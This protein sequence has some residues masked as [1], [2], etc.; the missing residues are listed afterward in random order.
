MSKPIMSSLSFGIKKIHD[1][2]DQWAIQ[3]VSTLIILSSAFLL[4][5][6]REG[7]VKDVGLTDT[8]IRDVGG[9]ITTGI[10]ILN[11]VNPYLPDGTLWGGARWGT[12]GTVPLAIISELIPRPLQVVFFQILGLLGFYLFVKTIFR[13]SPKLQTYSIFL[14]VIWSSSYREMLTTNQIIG[15]VLGLIALGIR[16]IF[17]NEGGAS[18]QLK[19]FLGTLCFV[20]ALD[21]KP[22]ISG[23]LIVGLYIYF[24]RGKDFLWLAGIYLITH[25]VVDVYLKRIVELDWVKIVTGLSDRANR[26]ELGDSVTFWPVLRRLVNLG[27]SFG[28]VSRAILLL[29]VIFTFL[30]AYRKN[31][32]AFFFLSFF[33]P[34]FSIYFHYY[35]AVPLFCLVFW[36]L[37]SR[38]KSIFSFLVLDML[39]ISKEAS[40]L[41]N[42][43]LVILISVLVVLFSSNSNSMR[44]RNLIYAIVGFIVWQLVYIANS[45]SNSNQ[46]ELQSLVVTEVLILSFLFFIQPLNSAQKLE[47]FTKKG[48]SS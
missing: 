33:T 15:I 32:H 7:G 37:L 27:N 43:L 8:S 47:I 20:I 31:W 16:S 12:F 30:V 3:A 14:L 28:L 2:L 9:Y 11:R 4:Y 42:I 17:L 25:A 29:L 5:Q 21:L 35:D 23:L 24:R 36:A 22:H 44:F 45:R 40:S 1:L 48:N 19:H 39:V 26:N 13:N 41:K 46:Y 6:Y 34:A 18:T 38:Q 10:K